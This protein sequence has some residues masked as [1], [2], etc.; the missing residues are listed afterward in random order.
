MFLLL[1]SLL[2]VFKHS[3]GHEFVKVVDLKGAWKFSIG[4]NP[5]WSDPDY[6]DSHWEKIYV[7]KSWEE[8]GFHGYDGYAWYRTTTYVPTQSIYSAYFLKLGYIDDVDEV[9]I[10]GIKIGHTGLFPPN[11]TT[12]YNAF[13][14]YRIPQKVMNI[15]GKIDIAI[16]VYDDGGE[17]GFIHGDISLVKDL[18][19][20][21]SDFDLQGEWKF[22]TGRC[23][24]I[25]EEMDYQNWGEIIV[26]GAWE[27]QGYK[28]YDGLACYVTEFE[29]DGQ[30][31]GE[32]MV[33]MLGRIDDLDRVYLNGT[34]IGQSG[35]FRTQTVLDRSDVY[36]T[37]RGYYIPVDILE[38]NGKNALVVKV[39]DAGG[40]GGIWEGTIGLITQDNYIQYWRNKR[41][42][43]R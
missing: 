32:R 38:D 36:Q 3:Q 17:G 13:R 14:Q 9:F 21:I 26:P 35:E 34:L 4:D 41:K 19:S 16:R 18:S 25:P 8:Q 33:L 6:D 20:I 10:N 28:G 29:L 12:A 27:D 5:K 43:T 11:Y 39:L 30:F 24:G 31:S 42:S 40:L 7:P 1:L 22:K 37:T 15:D 2:L 23:S